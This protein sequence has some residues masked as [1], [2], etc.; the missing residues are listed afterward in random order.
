MK[1]I[2][3]KELIESDLPKPYALWQH[4][5][6][7]ALTF[8]GYKY[9]GSFEKCAEVANKHSD[10]TLTDLRTCLFFEERR[11]HQYGDEPN[12]EEMKYIHNVVEKIRERIR[13]GETE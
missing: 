8:N 12:E 13:R 10:A 2:A 5:A 1:E 9:W 11:W 6:D 4:V 3:N 7:F